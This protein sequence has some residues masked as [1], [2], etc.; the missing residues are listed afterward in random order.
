VETGFLAAATGS[1]PLFLIADT[2]LSRRMMALSF[3]P[4]TPSL[5]VLRKTVG[6]LMPAIARRLEERIPLTVRVDLCSLDVRHRAQECLTENVSTHGAR[7]VS[8]TPWKLNERLNLWSLPGDFRA[9]ARVAYCK[10]FGIDSFA[11]GLQLLA[12]AGEWK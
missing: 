4:S 3:P 5:P 9:R 8:S 7:V 11:I 10:P 2:G 1:P 12:S 6:C